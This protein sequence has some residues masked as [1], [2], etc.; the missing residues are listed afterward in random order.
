MLWAQ[1]NWALA[2]F[3]MF[4]FLLWRV[5]G[6]SLFL[7]FCIIINSLCWVYVFQCSI[8]QAALP[9]SLFSISAWHFNMFVFSVSQPQN[10]P[11]KWYLWWLTNHQLSLVI[12]IILC[13]EMVQHEEHRSAHPHY[14]ALNEKGL[15]VF[16]SVFM[17]GCCV[18]CSTSAEHWEGFT[19][20]VAVW[21]WWHWDIIS[22]CGGGMPRVSFPLLSHK[23]H[24]PQARHTVV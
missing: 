18:P 1:W 21:R 19:G 10:H 22:L 17:S 7:L 14:N 24:K 9:H 8:R 15:T 2:L 4:S 12:A 5:T 6:Y 23:K 20:T 16:A 3:S 11:E 13:F